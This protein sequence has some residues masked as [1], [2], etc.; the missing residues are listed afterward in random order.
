MRAE[1]GVTCRLQDGRSASDPGVR[2]PLIRDGP[3][4]PVAATPGAGSLS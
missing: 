4:A 3:Q 2:K 1:A